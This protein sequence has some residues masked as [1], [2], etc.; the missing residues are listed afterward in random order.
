MRYRM[1]NGTTK[2]PNRLMKVP[3]KRAQ[4]AG[5][6][7]RTGC[8]R[9]GG[10]GRPP[11]PPPGAPRRPPPAVIPNPDGGGRGAGRRWI[12]ADDDVADQARAALPGV[13]RRQVEETD[14][15][16]IF[17]LRRPGIA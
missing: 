15:G 12:P 16:E 3:A 11:A 13:L 4:A 5:G 6:R 10:A 7:P 14:P 1:R 9:L 17:S 8:R 2:L